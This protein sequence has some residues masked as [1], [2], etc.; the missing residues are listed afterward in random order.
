MRCPDVAELAAYQQGSSTS[1]ERQRVAEHLSECEDCS[2]RLAELAEEAKYAA[3]ATPPPRK[4][5]G[6]ETEFYGSESPAPLPT[7][8]YDTVRLSDFDESSHAD[9]PGHATLPL[10][11]GAYEL[12]EQIGRGGM[13]V[14]YKARDTRLQRVVAVKMISAGAH[15]GE[16]AMLRFRREGEAVARLKHPSV[17]QVHEL[18]FHEG[19]PYLV[20]EFL[21]GGSL[22]Q[23]LAAGPIPPRE[24]AEIVKTVA[25]AVHVAHGSQILHRDLKPSN[26]LLTADGAPKLTDFGLAKLLDDEESETRSGEVLGTAAYMAPEQADGRVADLGPATDVYGLG[27]ILYDALA[28]RPPFKAQNRLATLDELR[29]KDPTP[30]SQHR[31]G[32]PRDLEAICLK[33]LAKRPDQRYPT[34]ERLA[35]DLDRW[36]LG[37]PTEARPARWWTLPRRHPLAT[38]AAVVLILA[39]TAAAIIQRVNDPDYVITRIENR[40]ARGEAVTLIGDQGAPVWSRWATGGEK[41]Q[42]FVAKD[43][44]FTL[45]SEP[46]ALLELVRD[47]ATSHYRIECE[48]RHNLASPEICEVGVFFVRRQYE[49][50]QVEAHSFMHFAFD[51]ITDSRNRI[52]KSL[53]A[54]GIANVSLPKK[55]E[56]GR[57]TLGQHFY[58]DRAY[59]NWKS[60]FAAD[61][62][63]TSEV[64]RYPL[65]LSHSWRQLAV[66]ITPEFVSATWDG[67]PPPTTF[68]ARQYYESAKK[69]LDI[70]RHRKP[71]SPLTAVFPT[72]FSP[73]GS[74]GLYALHGSVSFRRFVITPLRD[75]RPTETMQ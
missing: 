1:A 65:K 68:T 57:A 58:T 66:E 18:N 13:G 14:V 2:R 73:K 17:V 69:T 72:E 15:A 28:G 32:V 26:V 6:A 7:S 30:P 10:W 27:A 5:R 3:T 71:R 55:D 23:R 9:P 50:P 47:P 12:R 34:A 51:D 53:E 37:K 46:L 42:A 36:L 70:H 8:A 45:Q 19:L 62:R 16:P 43:G 35:Q 61:W 74:V 49:L 31:S 25:E 59:E 39:L 56:A 29:Y 67:N 63:Y 21:E 22:Q 33:C 41:A 38:A 40:L 24:A 4:P 44:T 11:V 75:E 64:A 48:A 54:A 60:E 20:M 52:A